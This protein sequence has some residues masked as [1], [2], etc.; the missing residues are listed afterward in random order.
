MH[1]DYFHASINDYFHAMT[2]R[3]AETCKVNFETLIDDKL[4]ELADHSLRDRLK[5]YYNNTVGTHLFA[6]PLQVC[7][8]GRKNCEALKVGNEARSESLN[9]CVKSRLLGA[10]V[11]FY[12]IFFA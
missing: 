4:G 2:A 5:R 3:K 10:C 9:S 6:S 1:H 12:F 7:N 8:Y 11:H